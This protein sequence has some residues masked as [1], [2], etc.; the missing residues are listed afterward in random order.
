MTSTR[1]AA[2]PLVSMIDPAAHPVR[3][4][5]TRREELMAAFANPDFYLEWTIILLALALA[6]LM[7]VLVRQQVKKRLA[8][9]PPKYIDAKFILQPLS[10][11]GPLL[12]LFYLS[13]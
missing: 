4:I 7:A 11:L 8:A 13:V 1:D 5:F 2:P 6:W 12:A 3:N 10:L 9:R